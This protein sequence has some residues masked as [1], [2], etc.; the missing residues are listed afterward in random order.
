LHW[1]VMDGA[2][3]NPKRESRTMIDQT[4]RMEDEISEFLSSRLPTWSWK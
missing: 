1:R 3:G 2:F 4:E